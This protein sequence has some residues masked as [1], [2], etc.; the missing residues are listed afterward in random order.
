M[1]T[2]P[3]NKLGQYIESGDSNTVIPISYC[4]RKVE[5][6]LDGGVGVSIMTRLVGV[7]KDL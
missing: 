1:S 2:V 3:I 6:I 7:V 4:Q 5:A